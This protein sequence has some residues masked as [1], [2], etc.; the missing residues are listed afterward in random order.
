MLRKILPWLALAFILF[1]I[2]R[3]PIGTAHLFHNAW[4]GAMSLADSFAT[5]ISHL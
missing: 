1:M 4:N 3:A 2:W 5:F